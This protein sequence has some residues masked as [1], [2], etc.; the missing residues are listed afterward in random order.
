MDLLITIILGWVVFFLTRFA[1]ECPVYRSMGKTSW[2]KA[3]RTTG[4]IVGVTTSVFF[5]ILLPANDALGVMK[6]ENLL[7]L[8]IALS[9]MIEG[10]MVHRRV[11]KLTYKT[12]P[13]IALLQYVS[14]YAAF[15]V[16]FLLRG[17]L[18]A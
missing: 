9:V 17:V 6:H 3:A 5:L 13:Y 2:R 14:W 15:M 7:I 16:M 12:A 8:M 11:V 1:L 4:G 10:W 18:T